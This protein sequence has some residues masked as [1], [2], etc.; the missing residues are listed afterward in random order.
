M[1]SVKKRPVKNFKA[2]VDF[3]N[4]RNALNEAA[5]L[6]VTDVKGKITFTNDKFCQ[7]SK[8]SREELIGQD[9]RIL[10]SGYHPKSFF[11]DLW[12][13]I[14]SGRVWRAE[15]RNRAKDR[16]FYWVDTTIIPVLDEKGK[17]REYM[18]IRYDIT[19]RKLME[20]S[21]KELSQRLILAQEKERSLIAQEI[22]DDFGQLL[23]ALKLFLTNQTW[24]LTAK[25]PELQTLCD[26][27]KA[28]IDQVIEKARNLSHDLAPPNLKYTGL[29][30][31]IQE[32]VESIPSD[33]NLSVKFSAPDLKSLD[34][35]A[36]DI[37]LYRIAQE[38][39]TNA[40]KHAQAR[41][42]RIHL[43]YEK[44][45][46]S[47]IIEDDGRG[48]NM[49]INGKTKKGLGLS[50]MNERAGLVGGTLKVESTAGAGTQIC[51]NMPIKEKANGQK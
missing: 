49:A 5:I 51:L 37:I 17:P 6:A 27:L 10:N 50:L 42:I 40:I 47:L 8:Y 22:H 18:A 35:E 41:N 3:S 4:L 23:V 7:I 34:F 30:Q 28:R 31:A 26:G 36:N 48:F 29:A 1:D 39:L 46:L 45:E 11:C 24:D 25:Y 38:A 14:A 12:E 20:E 2:S 21:I 16:S 15:I 33:K 9:H 19:P 32:L 13:T 44:G 43:S